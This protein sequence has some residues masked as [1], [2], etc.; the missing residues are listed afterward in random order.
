MNLDLT[1]AFL[2]GFSIVLLAVASIAN[3]HRAYHATK[4]LQSLE[5]RW[6]SQQKTLW[7]LTKDVRALER[8]EHARTYQELEELAR[9]VEEMGA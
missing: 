7:E 6:E 3:S 5:Q 8:Q 4:Q 9:K 1:I 2:T